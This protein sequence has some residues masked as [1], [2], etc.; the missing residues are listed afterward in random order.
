M[1]WTEPRQFRRCYQ[2]SAPALEH[3]WPCKREKL[4]ADPD[5]FARD[6][7]AWFF[8]RFGWH[9]ESAGLLARMQEGIFSRH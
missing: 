1:S 8:E 9:E 7:C 3:A 4:L 6:A 5:A 2:A